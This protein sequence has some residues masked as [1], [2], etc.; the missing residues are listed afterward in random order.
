MRAL[1]FWGVLAVPTKYNQN[2]GDRKIPLDD[3]FAVKIGN[4]LLAVSQIG[5][6]NIRIA[7]NFGRWVK[8]WRSRSCEHADL[9]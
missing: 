4:Y 9:S 8:R 1:S 3:A 2:C 6:D 7:A 5:N